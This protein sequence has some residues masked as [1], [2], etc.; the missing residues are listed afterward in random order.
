MGAAPRPPQAQPS[1]QEFT[2]R[3]TPSPEIKARGAIEAS[4]GRKTIQEN[5][6]EHA[7]N[8]LKAAHLAVRPAPGQSVE[9]AAARS[10]PSRAQRL[11]AL[12]APW[13]ASIHA[14]LPAHV[15]SG[16][17][18]SRLQA[19]S[20]LWLWRRRR[21]VA[22]SRSSFTSTKVASSRDLLSWPGCR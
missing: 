1:P 22:V 19:D 8:W 9:A 11:P 13:P 21:A 4:S 3:L 12:C 5:A 6:A 18:S 20:A 15:P 2:Q 10:R 16:K 17:L 7:M 14:V